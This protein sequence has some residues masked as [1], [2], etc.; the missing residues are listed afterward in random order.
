M[1]VVVEVRVMTLPVM[2]SVMVIRYSVMTPL[3]SS[4]GGEAQDSEK[5]VELAGASTTFW[6][7]LDGAE[8]ENRTLIWRLRWWCWCILGII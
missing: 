3:M 8:L 1:D 6:G 7:G 4:V 2:T 5:E